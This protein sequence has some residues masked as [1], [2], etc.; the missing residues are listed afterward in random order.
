MLYEAAWGGNL[1]VDWFDPAWWHNR[2]AVQGE[3]QGRGTTF[4]VRAGTDELV[5]R[6]YRRGGL[7]AKLIRDRYWFTGAENTR[8]FRE[9]SL[10]HLLH[11]RGLPVPE[12]VAARYR[13][14][15]SWYG[16]DLLT[17]RITGTQSLA[18]LLAA[19]SVSLPLWVAVGRCIRRFHDA[20]VFHADLNAHNI[21]LRDD[22]EAYL[23]DFDRGHL[24]RRRG[25]W[26]DSNLVRLRRSIDKVTDVLPPGRFSEPDWH[27]LLAAYR[28]A[29][30]V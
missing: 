24:H 8:S 14:H 17:R 1:T 4:F 26:C 30:P 16:C 10:L 21:L 12:P 13:R 11:G 27:S 19:G 18:Q 23:I 25:I 9:W 5:L 15:G 20:L 3:A 7:V 28:T 29:A 2:G 22:G 6:H